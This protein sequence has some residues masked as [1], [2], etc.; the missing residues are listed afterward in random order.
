MLL[1]HQAGLTLSVRPARN[2]LGDVP[3]KRLK[4][5]EKYA[6]S[7]NPKLSATPLTVMGV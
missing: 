5:R 4:K 1:A 2:T 7:A 3:L 6:G